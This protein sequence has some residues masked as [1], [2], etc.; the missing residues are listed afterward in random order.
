MA[1]KNRH[2]RRA[3]A[4]TSTVEKTIQLPHIRA[5]DFREFHCDG[6]RVRTD[7]QSVILTH[8]INDVSIP[9]E[10][11]EVQSQNEN[12]ATYVPVGIEEKRF[13]TDVCAVRIPVATF[14]EMIRLFHTQY[15][16]VEK[17]LAALSAKTDE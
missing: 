16:E 13:R 6:A 7:S 10:K 5:S 17:Q 14:Q 12:V 8:F 4:A 1:D 15:A 3:A 2:Q 11:M 9:F